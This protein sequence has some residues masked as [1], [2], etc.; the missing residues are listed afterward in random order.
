MN[1][2][3]L[4][5]GWTAGEIVPQDSTYLDP[6]ASP[7]PARFQFYGF[8]EGDSG[9]RLFSVPADTSVA[10]IVAKFEVGSHGAQGYNYDEAST[11]EMVSVKATAITKIA[12]CQV[13]F[14]DVA[15]LKLKFGRQIEDSDLDQLAK[16][17]PE[18]EGYQSGAEGYI[19]E[20]EPGRHLF[21]RVKEENIFHFWWD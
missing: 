21:Q 6:P 12:S 1:L 19:D 14:A 5:D 2:D 9:Y 11:I 15:G 4:P 3:N 7:D 8:L 10:E 18:D 17:F 16:L 13:I 20:Q